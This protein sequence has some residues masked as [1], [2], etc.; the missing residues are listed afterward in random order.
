MVPNFLAPLLNDYI[1]ILNP[2]QKTDML[3]GVLFYRFFILRNQ[4]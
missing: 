4:R 1:K 3:F 2:Y